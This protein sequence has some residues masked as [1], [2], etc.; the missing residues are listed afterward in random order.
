MLPGKFGAAVR[1]KL[2]PALLLAASVGCND[3]TNP[4]EVAP[5]QSLAYSH[6]A[7][8][9]VAVA[10]AGN[11]VGPFDNSV[12]CARRGLVEYIEV[13]A[14]RQ[15]TFTGCDT[16]NDI[17][18]DGTVVIAGRALDS[19]PVLLKTLSITTGLRQSN[20]A[21]S[22][23]TLAA[24]SVTGISF[25]AGTTELALRL[26]ESTVRIKEGTNDFPLDSRA[27]AEGI[28]SPA[29]VGINTISNPANN[30]DG[31]STVDVRRLAVYDLLQLSYLL[32]GETLES[33]RG[34]HT[35]TLSCGSITVTPEGQQPTLVRLTNAWNSCDLGAGLFVSG[36][37]QQSWD[38]FSNSRLSMR[39]TG[40]I[41]IG[42]ATPNTVYSLIEW[43]LDLPA[44]LP[45]NGEFSGRLVSNGV[46]RTFR[47]N[48]PL[49]D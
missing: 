30:A 32:F 45:G 8:M 20:A 24:F 14:G 47:F 44:S 13:A 15:A 46:A 40:P 10:L 34:A 6:A 5:V 21:G 26:R 35:H 29:T 4:V 36:N 23:S 33:A 9:A 1:Y 42:G 2:F 37:F 27:S 38:T 18:L 48:V 11:G 25:D 19:D 12:G 16:G 22:S 39:I 7:V 43:T 28:L 17:V 49:D 31:L 41:T 3:S